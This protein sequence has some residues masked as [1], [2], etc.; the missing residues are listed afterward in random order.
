LLIIYRPYLWDGL[1][2]IST[3][4]IS[5]FAASSSKIPEKYFKVARD[6]GKAIAL[7]GNELVFG[8]G[9]IGLMGAMADEALKNKGRVTGVIPRFMVENGWGHASINQTIVTE[10]MN[11]RKKKIFEISDAVIALPGGVGTLEELTEAI[12]LKQLS[13]FKGPVVI[14]NTDGFYT[15]LLKYFDELV[16]QNFM[17]VEHKHMWDIASEPEEAIKL[18]QNY[19]D[20]DTDYVKIARI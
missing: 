4:K 1:F 12:T 10:D 3:M 15:T 13:L 9:G 16:E 17:R 8:A 2:N 5:V 11:S 7:S 14:I 6:L 19:N 20:W 18:V